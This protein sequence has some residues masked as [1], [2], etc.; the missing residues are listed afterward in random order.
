[1]M[2]MLTFLRPD[3]TREG[4]YKVV[5][6]AMTDASSYYTP[7]DEDLLRTHL[8]KVGKTNVPIDFLRD[9]S[10][11]TKVRPSQNGKKKKCVVIPHLPSIPE[12]LLQR[13]YQ[14]S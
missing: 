6:I 13:L 5:A 1:M 3:V 10:T 8:K 12:E 7:P 14:G 4:R 9:T 2:Q 11:D